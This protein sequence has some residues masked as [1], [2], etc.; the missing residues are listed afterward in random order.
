M[1]SRYYLC[2][3]PT[4]RFRFPAIEKES[5]YTCPKCGS[6]A[7][8][9]LIIQAESINEVE[10]DRR[11][12]ISVLLDNIR[13]AHN[14]GSIFRTADGA[15]VSEI[16]LS[17]ITPSPDH[18]G[19][20]KTSLGA[21]NTV[22]WKQTWNALETCRQYQAQGYQLIVLERVHGAVP[23]TAL[24]NYLTGSRILLVV[25]NENIGI[26]PE[27]L[28]IA[29]KIIFLPMAGRKESLNVSVAFGICVYWILLSS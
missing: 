22:S 15:G 28:Q 23:I 19:A 25:G 11:L 3:K 7:E 13:S 16:L 24:N 10:N 9:I 12:S 4:C 29:D 26:D 27:I 21:E 8:P 5:G 17:G 1:K 18:P 2:Q 14:V 6:P 20:R